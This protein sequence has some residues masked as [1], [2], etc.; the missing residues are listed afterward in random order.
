MTMHKHANRA[1]SVLS[2]SVTQTHRT[3]NDVPVLNKS[4]SAVLPNMGTYL[5]LI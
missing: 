2:M 3:I 1:F 5:I 4:A